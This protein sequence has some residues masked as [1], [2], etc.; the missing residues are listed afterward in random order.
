M[1]KRLM[2]KAGVLLLSIALLA[3]FA[4]CQNNNTPDTDT[5]SVTLDYTVKT[6]LV[7]ANDVG[8]DPFINGYARFYDRGTKEEP[9]KFD[10]H[11]GNEW[12]Y[13]DA[14]GNVLFNTPYH[15]ITYF[16]QDG[17][18]VAK[19]LYYTDEEIQ[20]ELATKYCIINT[21]NEIVETLADETTFTTKYYEF[22]SVE[23]TSFLE[24]SQ[25]NSRGYK[26]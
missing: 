4:G 21:Q 7:Y 5:Q 1:K 26:V 16:N 18:A 9:N 14:K 24:H 11:Y 23:D 6:D 22:V 10:Y 3:S 8:P 2:Y 19:Q 20:M 17:L 12:N 13:I 15:E 25:T